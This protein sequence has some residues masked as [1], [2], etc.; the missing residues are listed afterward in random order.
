MPLKCCT[1]Y[2]SKFRKP[3]S[4]H[5]TGKG[6]SSSQFPMNAQPTRQ[7]PSPPMLA[8]LCSKSFKLGFSNMWTRKFQIYKL[9][10]VEAEEPKIKLPTF[11]GSWRN[12]ENSR[13]TF[14][15]VS[16]IT[17]QLFTM[18]ITT[19]CGKFF[20]RWEYQTTLPVFWETCMQIKKKQLE[21]DMEKQTASK[22]GKE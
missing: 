10:Y 3:S 2:V 20:K 9:C 13:K 15:S 22:L 18:W 8:R 11:F 5:K 4:G 7:L 14:T 21:L 19:N 16:L 6:Q 1:H 17:L 12:K